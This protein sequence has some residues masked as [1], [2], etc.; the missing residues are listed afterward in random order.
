MTDLM[1]LKAE[2][3]FKHFYI[4]IIYEKLSYEN[5]RILSSSLWRSLTSN[6]RHFVINYIAI[7]HKKITVT[8]SS[9]CILLE[10]P[11]MVQ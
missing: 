5:M 7:L 2:A 9:V 11:I 1:K 4:I 6:I 3:H 10:L 8:S